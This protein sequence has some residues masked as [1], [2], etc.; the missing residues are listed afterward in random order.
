MEG[1]D[2]AS[3]HPTKYGVPGVQVEWTDSRVRRCVIRTRPGTG[4]LRRSEAYRVTRRAPACRV[5]ETS[6]GR[7]ELRKPRTKDPGCGPSPRGT[8]RGR[9]RRSRSEAV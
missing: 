2:I 6:S 9:G 5:A 7:A 3:S 1:K 8:R 4:E